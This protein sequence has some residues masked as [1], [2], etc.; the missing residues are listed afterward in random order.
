MGAAWARH[1][2]CESALIQ[3]ERERLHGNRRD[4][5]IFNPPPTF[6]SGVH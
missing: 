6:K 1:A 4:R 3:P 5:K 2:M